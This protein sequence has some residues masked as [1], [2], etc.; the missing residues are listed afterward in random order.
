M[1]KKNLIHLLFYLL[2]FKIRTC[3]ENI[4]NFVKLF[5]KISFRYFAIDRFCVSHVM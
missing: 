3:V 5:S 2:L 1:N 4:I